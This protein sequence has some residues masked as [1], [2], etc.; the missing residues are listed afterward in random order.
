[1]DIVK[2]NIVSIICGVIAL[3]ALVAIYIWPLN[4]YYDKLKTQADQ[5]AAKNDAIQRV[6][7]ARR[8]MPVFDP[9]SPG[10]EVLG[11]FPSQPIIDKGKAALLE[12]QR[13]SGAM[14]TTAVNLNKQGHDVLVPTVLPDTPQQYLKLSFRPQMQAGLD[15]LRTVT[16]Q[17]GIPPTEDEIKKRAEAIWKDREKT[18]IIVNGQP[19]NL[20]QVQE[21]FQQ[22]VLKLPEVMRKE[23][24]TK[25]KMYVDPVAVMKIPAYLPPKDVPDPATIWWAQVEYWVTKDTVEAIAE[26]NKDSKSVLDSPIKNLIALNVPQSF[27]PERQATVGPRA[28][29]AGGGG[30]E[31]MDPRASVGPAPAAPPDPTQPVPDGSAQSP[32]KRVSNNLYDVVHYSVVVHIEAQQVPALLKALAT[33]RFITVV[34]MNVTAVDSQLV[35]LQGYVYGPRPVVQLEL[36]CEALFL[37]KWTLPLMPKKVKDAV[38]FGAPEGGVGGFGGGGREER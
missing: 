9:D 2:K 7:N 17:A 12:V 36:E 10:S 3:V 15:K 19:T 18:I 27:F 21:S 16:L 28:G 24:A 13:A 23:M 37:R 5:R 26:V 32:T 1:M 11:V 8:V 38:G 22:E 31:E 25:Y 33:N 4:G 35:Q 20:Q 29:A 30:G 34:G 6:L 14:Y